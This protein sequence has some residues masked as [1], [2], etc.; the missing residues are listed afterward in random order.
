[1]DVKEYYALK[2]IRDQMKL[3]VL[4]FGTL[5]CIGLCIAV[6]YGLRILNTPPTLFPIGTAIT[7]EEGLSINAITEILEKSHVVRSG[8][9]LYIVLVQQDKDTHIQAGNYTFDT[10]LS[11]TEVVKSLTTGMYRDPLI[12]VTFPEGFHARDMLEYLGDDFSDIPLESFISHE[13]Y[14]FP[15][16]YFVTES[17]TAEELL[18][19]L[20][21]THEAKITP[22]KNQIDASGFTQA[23]VV[24]LASLVEREAKDSTSKRMVSGILQNR[25]RLDMPLQVDATFDY[26]L[27]KTSDELTMDDL[28][29]DSPF[30][31]YSHKGLP[32]TPIAN[33]GIDAIEA[34][35]SPQVSSYLYYL[36]SPDGT[37][38]YAETFEEHKKNKARYLR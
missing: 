8:L 10:P 25:L 29:I 9:Y 5:F 15:D 23:E 21:T 24:I 4:F 20:T 18:A 19:L 32:P 30:N 31:T 22:Y 28:K 6:W 36:T 38:Y 11:V 7:I 35:L 34:V 17:I 33:P 26:V 37:F 13:G 14:L 1:M 3:V 12:S 27:D 2:V 16:T